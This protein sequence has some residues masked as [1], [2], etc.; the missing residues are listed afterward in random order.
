MVPVTRYS[1]V[2]GIPV[3]DLIAMGRSSQDKIDAIVKRTANG[4][5]EIVALLKTGSAPSMP[6]PPAPSP[7]PKAIW[8]T[9][10]ASCPAP[11][12]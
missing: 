5:G 9:R 2:K 4:G 1:T 11:R 12:I 7:W 8:A 6:P 10:S 3:P